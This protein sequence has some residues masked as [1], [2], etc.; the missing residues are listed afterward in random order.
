MVIEKTLKSVWVPWVLSGAALN[1]QVVSVVRGDAG[2]CFQMPT[3]LPCTPAVPPI[4]LCSSA[5]HFDIYRRGID[6]PSCTLV[7]IPWLHILF[8]FKTRL[9]GLGSRDDLHFISIGAQE[10]I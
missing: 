9:A 8:G 6:F 10:F 2:S 5:G 3:S 4:S 1:I 7:P